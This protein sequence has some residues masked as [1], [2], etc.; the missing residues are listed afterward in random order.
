MSLRAAVLLTTAI[1]AGA[2]APVWAG[3]GEGGQAGDPADDP[4]LASKRDQLVGAGLYT[5]PQPYEGVGTSLVPVPLANLSYGR[6][7]VYGVEGGF[8]WNE[9][10]LL[11]W[12]VFVGPRFM[13]YEA[14]ES[15]ILDGMEERDF[16]GDAGAA[17]TL[18]PIPF[19]VDLSVRTDIL[20]RSD[21][22]EV[23]LDADLLLPAG[24]WLLRPSLG[25]QWQ[26]EEM[27]DYYY[28]VTRDEARPG[29]PEHG[30]AA[31]LSWSAEIEVSREIGSRW[32]FA[33]GLTTDRLGSGITDSP[34]VDTSHTETGYIGLL[35]GF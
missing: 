13:G 3:T 15:D 9:R 31:T 7:Y 32:T 27:V 17:V 28:G 16:S 6:F 2:P 23:T 12:R 24:S 19:I 33:A 34:L 11:G 1:W 5:V 8:R 30:G 20:G 21:G 25:M 22:E 18:R 26:S 35:F 4:A 14:G 10:S 29:R